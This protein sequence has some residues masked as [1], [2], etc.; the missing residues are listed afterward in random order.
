MS[1]ESSTTPAVRAGV[2]GQVLKVFVWLEN[3]RMD[4]LLILMRIIVG[5]V[6]FMSAQTKV[7]GF[8]IKDSTFFLFEHE[9]GLPLVS[10][11]LAAW[12]AT[13]AEHLF[14][15][16]LWLG[17]GTRFAALGLAVMT[18]TIQLFVYP[19]AWVTHGLWLSSLLVLVLQGPGRLSLDQLIRSRI[20]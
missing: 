13:I 1:L 14:P 11:I 16:M 9:Y 4:A 17:L 5:A 20:A 7:D 10:P 6:F 15:L 3:L 2:A 12:L 19:H 18:L 8:T